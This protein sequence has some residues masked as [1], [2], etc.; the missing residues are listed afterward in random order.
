ML[1]HRFDGLFQRFVVVIKITNPA[2]RFVIVDRPKQLL[3]DEMDV[4]GKAI[5]YS[6]D[7]ILYFFVKFDVECF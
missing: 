6:S 1:L 3:S 7:S 4:V 5:A 2:R